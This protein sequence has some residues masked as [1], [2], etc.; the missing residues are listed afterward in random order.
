MTTAAD[1]ILPAG[2]FPVLS[3]PGD[4]DWPHWEAARR[5][6]IAI[7]QCTAC[8]RFQWGPEVMCHHC[9]S[10]ELTFAPVSTTGRIYSWERV[11]HPIRAELAPACPYVTVLV[12]V[13]EAPGVLL[14]GNLVGDPREPVTIGSAVEAVFEHHEDYTL[15]QWRRAGEAS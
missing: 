15:V 6:V 10:S 14:I 7:Q 2:V 11:W 4:L 12:E 3:A 9:L 13:P 5:E 1:Y 8:Q